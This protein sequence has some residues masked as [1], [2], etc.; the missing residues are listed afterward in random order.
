MA[1]E[2]EHGIVVESDI[3]ELANTS[4]SAEAVTIGNK[5]YTIHCPSIFSMQKVGEYLA[6]MATSE[7]SG[8]TLDEAVRMMT[9]K[10]TMA[11]T[12]SFILQDDESLAEELTCGTS[13]E[14]QEAII[15]YHAMTIQSMKMLKALA[16]GIGKLIGKQKR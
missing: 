7:M 15:V 10:Q 6:Q 8:K 9:D 13:E 12:V 4:L 5:E 16:A 2:K 11:K 1:E 3:L 14:L